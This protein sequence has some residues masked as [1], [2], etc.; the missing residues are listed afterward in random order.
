LR[1]RTDAPP[2]ALLGATAFTQPLIGSRRVMTIKVPMTPDGHARLS[3]E[4][5]RLKTEERPAVI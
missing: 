5:R 2:T 1:T 4:L 3:A